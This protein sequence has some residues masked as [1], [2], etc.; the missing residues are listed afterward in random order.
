MSPATL[1][2]GC[3]CL[4]FLTKP[5]TLLGTLPAGRR[6]ELYDNLAA[7]SKPFSDVEHLVAGKSSFGD[8]GAGKSQHGIPPDT[9]MID[10]DQAVWAC[11][12]IWYAQT[13]ADK[14][15]GRPH[16]RFVELTTEA[17]TMQSVLS[18]CLVSQAGLFRL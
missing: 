17:A 1:A 3:P 14:V 12:D 7:L 13:E 2:H 5:T 11:L 15:R 10:F 6:T 16:A 18:V 8:A 4:L 9:R